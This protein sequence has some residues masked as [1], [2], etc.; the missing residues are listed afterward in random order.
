MSKSDSEEDLIFACDASPYSLDA[1]LSHEMKNNTKQP[2]AFASRSLATADKNYSSLDKEAL[3]IV[4]GVNN[5]HQYE[6]ARQFTILRDQKHRERVY[7]PDKM[8]PPMAAA[9]IQR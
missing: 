3:Y 6:Y 9:R 2:I 4:F 1:F 7:H 5:F 8:T